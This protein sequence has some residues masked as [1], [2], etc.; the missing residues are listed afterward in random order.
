[1]GMESCPPFCNLSNDHYNDPHWKSES[2]WVLAHWVQTTRWAF[3]IRITMLHQINT[4][5]SATASPTFRAVIPFDGLLE[6]FLK[7]DKTRDDPCSQR[8]ASSPQARLFIS[9]EHAG[10]LIRWG[11]RWSETAAAITNVTCIQWWVNICNPSSPWGDWR[12]TRRIC[13]PIRPH[14]DVSPIFFLAPFVVWLYW[15]KWAYWS[16]SSQCRFRPP[17]EKE[18]SGSKGTS[19]IIVD[20]SSPLFPDLRVHFIV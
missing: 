8:H 18:K 9:E 10:Q 13:I 15:S 3:F 19:P 17:C 7:H 5:A 14:I 20:Q 11:C 4:S 12:E 2:R 6:G 1:M 16:W